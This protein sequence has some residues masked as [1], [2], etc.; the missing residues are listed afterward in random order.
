MNKV[1]ESICYVGDITLIYIGVDMIDRQNYV[2]LIPI[3]IG[4]ADILFYIFKK[5]K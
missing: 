3:L 2:G 4:I 5:N 1:I